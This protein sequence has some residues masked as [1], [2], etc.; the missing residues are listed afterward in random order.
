MYEAIDAVGLDVRVEETYAYNGFNQLLTVTG[1]DGAL[2]TYGY[3]GN[4]N[5]TTEATRTG[6]V[7]Q[8]TSYGYDV[9]NRLR[10]VT[11]PSGPAGEPVAQWATSATASSQ[12][13]ATGSWSASQATGAPNTDGCS[14][15][16]TAWS[17]AGTGLGPEWLRVEYAVPVS[18]VGVK[19]HETGGAGSVTKVEVIDEGGSRTRCG[20]GRTGRCAGSGWR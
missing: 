1:G 9:D 11:V 18:A 17:A 14:A 6:W 2:T 16:G 7:T 10:T 19:V 13:A 12:A 8:R 4:G 20:R 3:D 5:Q 15:S